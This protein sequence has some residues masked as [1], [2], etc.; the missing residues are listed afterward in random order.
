MNGFEPKIV[1]RRCVCRP[2]QQRN[3]PS[4]DLFATCKNCGE[5]HVSRYRLGEQ[6]EFDWDKCPHCGLAKLWFGT[7][8]EAKEYLQGN[9]RVQVSRSESAPP[10]SQADQE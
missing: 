6:P 9:Y 5:V 7:S 3:K 8:R 4:Y 10:K 1:D 2:C